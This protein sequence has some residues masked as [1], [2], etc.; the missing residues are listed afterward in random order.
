VKGVLARTRE[1]LR[2]QLRR[3]LPLQLYL[4][5]TIGTGV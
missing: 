3:N 4:A 1:R 2:S 5:E